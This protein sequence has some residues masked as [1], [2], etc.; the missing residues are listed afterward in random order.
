MTSIRSSV[1]QGLLLG[2]IIIGSLG[3]LN[4]ITIGLSASIQEL[5]KANPKFK[6]R[7][8]F[9]SGMRIGSEH[10]AALVNTLALAYAG[11]ALPLFIYIVLNPSNQPPWIILNSELL[12]EEIVRTLAGSVG[13]ILAVPLTAFLGAW[14]FQEKMK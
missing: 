14:A 13:L 7:E 8:L 9:Q 3:V 4:D 6:L 12:V 11:A 1:F 2:G 5:A 10:I